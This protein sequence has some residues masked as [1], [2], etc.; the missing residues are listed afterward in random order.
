MP[1]IGGSLRKAHSPREKEGQHDVRGQ[2][3]RQDRVEMVRG[4]ARVCTHLH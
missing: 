4:V 2:A 1:W 3:Q